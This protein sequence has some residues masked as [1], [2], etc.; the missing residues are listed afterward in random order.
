MVE[1]GHGTNPQSAQS[2]LLFN[3][4]WNLTDRICSYN[5]DKAE[6]KNYAFMED[7]GPLC[8]PEF[9]KKSEDHAV[10]YYD[11]VCGLPLF[12]APKGRS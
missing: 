8:W 4:D 6:P 12:T 2:D 1:S 11:S 3:C 5:R 7:R 9:L 10:M